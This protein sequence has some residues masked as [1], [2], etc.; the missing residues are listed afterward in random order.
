[1]TTYRCSICQALVT[2][3]EEFAVCN[4]TSACGLLFEDEIVRPEAPAAPAAPVRPTAKSLRFELFGSPSDYVAGDDRSYEVLHRGIVI[5]SVEPTFLLAA[6]PGE[7]G[8]RGWYFRHART[9]AYGE[10]L[11]RAAAVL[12]SWES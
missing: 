7:Q 3:D 1:M 6:T 2:S 9:N 10:G 11:T 5:G 12:A 4:G 8:P